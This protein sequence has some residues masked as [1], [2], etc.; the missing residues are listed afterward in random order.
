[1]LGYGVFKWENKDKYEGE[2]K[3]DKKTGP[4]KFTW[5]S[6]DYFEGNWF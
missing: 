6:G 5:A 3:N 4:G 2:W 1:M